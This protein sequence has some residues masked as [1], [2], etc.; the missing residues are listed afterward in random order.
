M[1]ATNK[2]AS[3]PELNYTCEICGREGFSDEEMRA[4]MVECHL[5]GEIN[6][7]FCDLSESSPAEM[8][9]HVNSAHLDYLTPR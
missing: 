4:H 8:L 5:E 9:S 6:C 3:V 2:R 7:P 1:E